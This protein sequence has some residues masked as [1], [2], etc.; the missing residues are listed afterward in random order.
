[1]GPAA[2]RAAV[3][4]FVDGP[5]SDRADTFAI[6]TS[7]NLTSSTRSHEVDLQRERLSRAGKQLEIYD[8]ERLAVELK[9]LPT[10]VDDFFGRAWVARFNG[11]GVVEGLDARLDRRVATATRNDLRAFYE[12]V[13]KVHDAGLGLPPISLEAPEDLRDLFVVPDLLEDVRA[14]SAPAPTTPAR[15]QAESQASEAPTSPD[16]GG[17]SANARLRISAEAWLS[18]H[19]RTVLVGDPGA[20]KSTLLRFLALDL[21]S[22]EPRLP[23]L[24]REWD[25]P[26][27][28]WVPFGRWTEVIDGGGDRSLRT[29]LRTWFEDLDRPELPE[30]Y[31]RALSDGR[32]V[33]LVDGLDEWKTEAAATVAFDQLRILASDRDV[34]VVATARP[35]A[36]AHL[37][38]APGD[39]RSAGLAE[40]EREQQRDV[41]ERLEAWRRSS[42]TDPATVSPSVTPSRLVEE[43]WRAA[44]LRELAAVPLTLVFLYW[45]RARDAR[46]PR[47]RFQ[48]YESL[49]DL[50][51]AKYPARRSAA[52]AMLSGN[53]PVDESDFRS[54]LGALAH[55]IQSDGS[56][57][58]SGQPAEAAV[59]AH[60]ADVENGPGFDPSEAR[61]VGR[62]LIRDAEERLGVL[63]QAAPQQFAFLHRS[64][65]EHLCAAHLSRFRLDSQVQL[66]SERGQDPVWTEVLLNLIYLTT[67]PDD[68]DT[69]VTALRTSR[70]EPTWQTGDPLMAEVA[71]GK[72]GCSARLARDLAHQAATASET[73][74]RPSLASAIAVRLLDGLENRTVSD[75]V[76][77]RTKTWF[78]ARSWSREGLYVGMRDWPDEPETDQALWRAVF[79]E[80][81]R[82]ARPA[83]LAY[84]SRRQRFGAGPELI[85]AALDQPL[86]PVTRAAI[87]EPFALSWP[88]HPRTRNEL[89]LARDSL[90]PDLRL[91]AIFVAVERGWHG[92][93]E[94]QEALNLAGWM[95]G[96]D[97]ARRDQLIRTLVRGWPRN[98]RL[99]EACLQDLRSSGGRELEHGLSLAVLLGAFP[100]DPDVI[101]YCIEQLRR[102]RFP[103]I[104]LTAGAGGAWRL[105]A[106]NFKDE[107]A[108]VRAVDEWIPKQEFHEPEVAYAALIGQTDVGKQRLL[109]DV[110]NGS[111][112]HW[113][114]TMLLAGWGLSDAEVRGTLKSV[115]FGPNDQAAAIAHLLR[116]IVGDDK[117]CAARLLELLED[118]TVRR[119]DLVVHALADLDDPTIRDRVVDLALTAH[120]DRNGSGLVDFEPALIA[121]A[122]Q[123]SRIKRLARASLR[124]RDPGF[125]ALARYYA[126]DTEMRQVL[127]DAASPLSV[128]VRRR[129]WEHLLRLGLADRELTSVAAEYPAEEQGDV[130]TL[131][132]C[133]HARSLR[134]EGRPGE[135]V[136]RAVDEMRTGSPR[137]EGHAQAALAAL[138]ELECLDAFV[139]LQFVGGEPRPF[140][141]PLTDYFRPNITLASM[142]VDH[143]N[144]VTEVL[145]PDFANRFTGITG[146]SNETFWDVISTVA[147]RSEDSRKALTEYLRAERPHL[148][149]NML[150][151]LAR[152]EPGSDHL[153]DMCLDTM[154]RGGEQG[155]AFPNRALTA[156]DILASQFHSDDQ[157]GDML[158]EAFL[159]SLDPIKFVAIAQA[160][161][162]ERF[163]IALQRARSRELQVPY[164]Y[165]YRAR[166][167]A[168]GVEAAVQALQDLLRVGVQQASH[169]DR[170]IQVLVQRLS[171]DSRLAALCMRRLRASSS[172]SSELAT[173]SRLLARAAVV[174]RETRD[175]LESLVTSV[176]GREI[177]VDLVAGS[178]RAVAHAVADALEDVR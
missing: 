37:G 23:L 173:Y 112:P 124:E 69:L 76:Q 81:T 178:R 136:D 143:W 8:S 99:K 13:F 174:S 162:G 63:F 133:A 31:E 86:T 103:F 111:F 96:I 140:S 139:D 163:R 159:S 145:G 89:E 102:E 34:R 60:L 166:I 158:V 116:A 52:A 40:L 169:M 134:I 43:L 67:R 21:L 47:D 146:S 117:R 88:D 75:F 46:L 127:R 160:W 18:G 26:I 66:V 71:A 161:P 175:E 87:L 16:R 72:F 2:I 20:G 149:S 27:P 123:D 50:L 64:V 144:H 55:A 142:V 155:R 38:P 62:E 12:Q 153:R 48:A 51:L 53:R 77:A 131:M 68:V 39:W 49:V 61:R 84:A 147:D 141:V 172:G 137:W 78:P 93:E 177:G 17:S 29:L 45:I 42:E 74:A 57:V 80:D 95:A 165:S 5:W 56:G 54:A 32:A 10:L 6:C 19:R 157:L 33:L 97:Y 154:E 83:A 106:D 98:P 125:W 110:Q 35:V 171:R 1:M 85:E 168:G 70:E 115:A 24:V 126:D 7:T 94:L 3:T 11:E 9:S 91:V 65:Q 79:S 119:A 101:E 128:E 129:C 108:L 15:G 25:A 152:T 132:A 22:P 104:S 73:F 170:P 105:L 150:A 118:K 122:P 41:L 109:Q 36:L 167:A 92:P 164:E 120:R 113:A 14:Y 107:P 44:D 135:A 148:T 151:F 90:D 114:G 156:C 30:L 59:Q 100:G 58:I 130:A 4:D 82:N 121:L 28:L 176:R 138:L